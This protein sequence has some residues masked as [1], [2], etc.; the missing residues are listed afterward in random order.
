MANDF[1]ENSIDPA[2]LEALMQYAQAEI[3]KRISIVDDNIIKFEI[4]LNALSNETLKEAK[5]QQIA[6]ALK[7]RSDWQKEREKVVKEN[8]AVFKNILKMVDVA[9]SSP[10]YNLPKTGTLKFLTSPTGGLGISFFFDMA[11]GESPEHALVSA[12]YGATESAAISAGLGGLA[13]LAGI[14]VGP[15]A[16]AVGGVVVGAAI[17]FTAAASW[18]KEF[19][20]Y[21]AGP[22]VEII[23][24]GN[25]VNSVS[26][27][28]LSVTI[29]S[30]LYH[31]WDAKLSNS[32]HWKITLY[33]GKN[34]VEYEHSID[35]LT[36]GESKT[37]LL[38]KDSNL[39]I[40]MHSYM[41]KDKHPEVIANGEN[42]GKVYFFDKVALKSLQDL[43]DTQDKRALT[44]IF[45]M[46]N[47]VFDNGALNT[48]DISGYSQKYIEKK[49]E[50][51]FHY[52]NHLYELNTA[53]TDYIDF[54]HTETNI[55][56]NGFFKNQVIF[57]SNDS[58]T[59]SLLQ[60]Q[61]GNDFIF[62]Q[63]GDDTIQG[64]SGSANRDRC[65]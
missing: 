62:G 15:F 3:D 53:A 12:L 61:G 26:I 50:H 42:L 59:A 41:G 7:I 65:C 28:V 37:T 49:I 11:K 14:T 57:D 40:L 39:D 58:H 64:G 38:K 29:G 25:E 17:T 44:A 8:E 47:L 18:S 24:I 35:R 13:A 51:F 54:V 46:Q 56:A 55:D 21:V 32:P 5:R 19:K 4:E 31:Y 36:F 60:G 34:Y 30:V 43:V 48:V 63:G 27:H 16:L 22:S 2:E 6:D 33:G 23:K 9:Y 45:N 52:T 20:D 1:I 10:D